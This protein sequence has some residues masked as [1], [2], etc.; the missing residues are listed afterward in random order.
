M[1][2]IFHRQIGHSSPPLANREA[3]ARGPKVYPMGG[4]VDV[5]ARRSFVASAESLIDVIVQRL[6]DTIDVAGPNIT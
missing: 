1:T 5:V 3:I 6:E 4:T 2:R